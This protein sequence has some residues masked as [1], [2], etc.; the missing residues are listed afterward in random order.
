M[1]NKLFIILGFGLCLASI[2]LQQFK[3][4]T[5]QTEL[6]KEQ[7]AIAN[8]KSKAKVTLENLQSE[9]N[10]TDLLLE[11]YKQEKDKTDLLREKYKQE[12][13]ITDLL[14]EY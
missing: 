2:F 8:I 11:K 6:E 3:I 7:N 9:K 4:H 14:L 1:K 10:K 12:K 13:A 5:L